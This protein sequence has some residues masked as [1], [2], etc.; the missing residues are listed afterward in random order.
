MRLSN[1]ASVFVLA[2][3]IRADVFVV[4]LHIPAELDELRHDGRLVDGEVQREVRAVSE[5]DGD[6]Q[7]AVVVGMRD[8]V[9]QP[10]ANLWKIPAQLVLAPLMF[11]GLRRSLALI[12]VIPVLQPLDL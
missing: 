1:R 3:E 7:P 9:E 2:T 6:V 10:A 5:V 11:E 4:S 8:V 12:F